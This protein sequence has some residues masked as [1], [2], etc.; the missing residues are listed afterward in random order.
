MFFD[1]VKDDRS[2]DEYTEEDEDKE[3]ARDEAEV[4]LFQ[5]KDE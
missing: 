1:V 5:K 4:K 3:D 2:D